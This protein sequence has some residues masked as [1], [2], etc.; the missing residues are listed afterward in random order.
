MSPVISTPSL[1]KPLDTQPLDTEPLDTEPL[2]TELLDS[3]P[4]DTQPVDTEAVDSQPSPADPVQGAPVAVDLPA[5]VLALA[6]QAATEDAGGSSAVGEFLGAV[7]EDEV[8]VS[9]AF[10]AAEPSYQGWYWSVTLALLD[11]DHPTV[12]EVVLLPGHGALLAPA[13]VPWDQRIR[14]G[15]IG[16][17]DLLVTP[18]DDDRL[19]P[20][21]LDSD[22]PAVQELSY[23]FGLGRVRVLSRQ[24][25]DDAAQRW[26]DGPYGPGSPM[27]AAAQANC[28]SCG[29]YAP[30]AGLLGMAMGVCANE[31]SP[32]DGRVVDAAFGCGA[33]S[34][35][36]IDAPLISAS[37]ASVV[38]ELTLEVHLRR[39]P[40]LGG[41]EREP[42]P[43][44]EPGP[45]PELEPSS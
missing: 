25:R 38:D 35:T 37:T 31:L 22:D 41:P 40:E 42:E 39:T 26:H 29:F 5:A 2:D 33:H 6:R 28:V 17:G 19:V 15:D 12:S 1:P 18:P 11:P 43:E 4:L 13:W 10:A 20:S 16:A 21:Y 44:P 3:Q 23:E 36:V 24:G 27:A 8:A 14:P 34:E 32:A 7:A 9:A 45:Q 30:L